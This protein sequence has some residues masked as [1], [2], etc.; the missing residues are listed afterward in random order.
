MTSE[1]CAAIETIRR[2]INSYTIA[3]DSRNRALFESLWADHALFE[4]DGF[5]PLPGFRREGIAEIRVGLSSWNPDRSKDPSFTKTSFIRHNLTTCL[6]DLTGPDTASARTYFIV[7]TEGGP[8][9][10][11][12]YDD[13]FVRQGDRWLFSHRRIQL[14]WRSPNGLFPPVKDG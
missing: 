10:A 5:P 14:V 11:G 13:E 6:I 2:T 3:G 12:N 8:D 4:F 7:Y 9:H 1:E